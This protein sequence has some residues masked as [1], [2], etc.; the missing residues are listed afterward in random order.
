MDEILR[1]EAN[2]YSLQHCN[3]DD[4]D[5]DDILFMLS[6]IIKHMQCTILSHSMCN[7]PIFKNFVTT[8]LGY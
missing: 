5:D 4:D 8:T 7:Q 6:N 1:D 3:I 2:T